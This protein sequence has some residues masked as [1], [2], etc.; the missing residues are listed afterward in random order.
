MAIGDVADMAA[1]IAAVLP[2]RW[3]PALDE[4]PVLSGL[5]QG[6]GAAWSH[7]HALVAYGR[8]Q[9]RIATAT[10]TFLDMIA[11]DYFAHAFRR[12]PQESDALFSA[13]I[14]ASLLPERATRASILATVNTATGATA[15][16]FEPTRPED[17]GAYAT[18]TAPAL[19]GGFGYGIV[20]LAYG[21]LSLPFQFLIDI[22]RGEATSGLSGIAGYGD[23]PDLGNM[24]G[25]YGIG[26]TAYGS[27]LLAEPGTSDA[28]IADAVRAALP[29]GVTAWMRIT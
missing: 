6:M 9:A 18:R 23:V 21:S 17:T 24:P 16:A 11:A 1:R 20:G 2:A 5:L 12:R 28:D 10:G 4:A 8:T 14:M 22:R 7:C 19:G 3:F 15:T 13:R 25:G 27:L 29:A 26:A